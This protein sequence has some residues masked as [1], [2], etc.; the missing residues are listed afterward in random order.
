MRK[1]FTIIT[2][3]II[4]T[5][6]L[7]MNFSCSNQKVEELKKERAFRIPIGVGEEEIGVIREQNGIF[8][9]PDS[10]LFKNGFFYVVDSVNQKILKI[11]NPGDVILVLAR[12]IKDQDSEEN[13]L[14]TK[15]RKHF[16]FNN[17]C[18]Q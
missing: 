7:F 16:Q 17:C 3:F 9:S 2:A 4:V 18:G 6:L 5:G 11:T 1:I 12:G 13:V 15:Q 10:L 14:R 8:S